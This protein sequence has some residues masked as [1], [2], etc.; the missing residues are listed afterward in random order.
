MDDRK[1]IVD[2]VSYAS[3]HHAQCGKPRRSFD[4]RLHLLAFGN[5]DG[6]THQPYNIAKLIEDWALGSGNVAHGTVGTDNAKFHGFLRL[7][8]D[9]ALRRRLYGGD[10]VWM[11][12][13]KPISPMHGNDS[14]YAKDRK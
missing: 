7:S 5:I 4:L 1:R 13:P 3:S 10:I 6:R 12:P 11:G 14:G 8:P 2:L 9:R